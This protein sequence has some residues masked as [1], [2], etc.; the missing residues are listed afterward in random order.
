MGG[1]DGHIIVSDAA[2]GALT[3]P[4]VHGG[5]PATTTGALD[6]VLWSDAPTNTVLRD[7]S[8]WNKQEREIVGRAFHWALCKAP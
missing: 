8:T 3:N 5:L 2:Q 1:G 6:P 7:P 4:V